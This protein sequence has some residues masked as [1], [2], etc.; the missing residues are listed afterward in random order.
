MKKLFKLTALLLC[1]SMCLGM[2]TGCGDTNTPASGAASNAAPLADTPQTLV[3]GK[4]DG[5]WRSDVY[6]D[7]DEHGS[8]RQDTD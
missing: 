1:L 4:T 5:G 6:R 7:A 8:H 2:L 3:Y